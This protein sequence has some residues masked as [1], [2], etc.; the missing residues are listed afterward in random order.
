MTTAILPRFH[1]NRKFIFLFFD[2][3]FN[4]EKKLNNNMEHHVFKMNIICGQQKQPVL[5]TEPAAKVLYQ[6]QV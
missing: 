4:H 3:R 6:S 5:E 2:E 1:N